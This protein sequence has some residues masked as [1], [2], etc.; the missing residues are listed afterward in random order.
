MKKIAVLVITLLLTNILYAQEATENQDVQENEKKETSYNKFSIEAGLG[1]NKADDNFSP[2][3]FQANDRE[4][5]AINSLNHFDL[6]FRYMFSEK[7]GLKLDGTYDKIKNE[8]DVSLPFK[9]NQFRIG[10]QGVINLRNLLNFD[11][12]TK[13][14]GL[15]GHA[16]VQSSFIN[17]VTRNGVDVS[18][19]TDYNGGFIFGF[20]PQYRISNRFVIHADA[21]FIQSYRSHITWD[22]VRTTE[23]NLN[24][25]MM[26][27]SMGITL[28]LGKHDVHAD[29]YS[30]D[31]SDIM[32]EKFGEF[33]NKIAE[34]EQKIA[35]TDKA[36]D[37]ETN[38][39]KNFITN[40]Y[41]SKEQVDVLIDNL[42]DVGYGNI[43]FGFNNDVPEPTSLNEISK[44]VDFMKNNP[45]QSIMLIGYTDVLGSENYNDDLSM[46]RAKFVNGILVNAGIDQSRIEFNGDGVNPEY[47]DK[48]DEFNRKLARRVKV[49]LK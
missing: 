28:N 47:K 29:F 49:V 6:G 37:D 14:F 38:D 1:Y 20:T 9:T 25:S 32:D 11:S 36:I 4:D 3:F 41:Y 10:L 31:K 24:S 18:G 34:L 17:P 7:F 22:G 12:F 15:L 19:G 30:V 5:F 44:L 27:I 2:G 46:R 35:D 39:I 48:K 40:N 16:G 21:S 26:N 33:N 8:G 45:D 43:F 13:R 23:K 42:K